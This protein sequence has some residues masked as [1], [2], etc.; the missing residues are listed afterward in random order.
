MNFGVNSRSA[1]KLF[2]NK[3]RWYR[4]NS[5]FEPSFYFGGRGR[6][7]KFEKVKFSEFEKVFGSDRDLYDSIILPKRGTKASA[8]YDFFALDD[9][10]IKSGEIVK[11]S[12]GIK[13]S[14]EEDEV[15]LLIIRSS[16]GFKHNIR[17]VNQVGVIDSDYYNN[18]DNDGHIMIKLQNH[19]V[20][21]FVIEKGKA[22]AQG[23][24]MKYLL[25]DDDVA[26]GER[27]GGIGSTTVK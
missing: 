8:G 25:T 26:N 5:P 6:M 27:K 1:L 15:L 19:G 3:K 10:V 12:T 2:E 14:M 9:I 24:F 7:R 23:L 18:P 13:S 22:F 17:I 20:N 11:I 16:L 4:D 21:D